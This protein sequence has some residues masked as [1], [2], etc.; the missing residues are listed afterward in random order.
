MQDRESRGS[1]A[2]GGVEEVAERKPEEVDPEEVEEIDPERKP[3]EPGAAAKDRDG[4]QQHRDPPRPDRNSTRVKNVT[5]EDWDDP[6]AKEFL[7]IPAGGDVLVAGD[8]V[9]W[10]CAV[11][12]HHSGG[13]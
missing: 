8:L 13:D 6:G 7:C 4:G 5:S 11:V 10:A 1:S 2:D 3:Q 12:R 9:T